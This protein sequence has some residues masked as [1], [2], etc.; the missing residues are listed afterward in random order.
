MNAISPEAV[1]YL[2]FCWAAGSILWA[3]VL[4]RV[5]GTDPSSEGSGNPGARNAGRLLGAPAFFTVFTGDALK[6]AAAVLA[7]R[8][9]VQPEW[10]IAAGGALAVFG[11]IFPLYGGKGGKGVSAFVGAALA[12]SPTAFAGFAVGTA[13]ALLPL[14]SATLTMP[15]GFAAWTAALWFSGMLPASWPL[16]LAAGLVL[17]RHRE[18]FRAAIRRD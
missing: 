4:G 15:G 6:G 7:G 8:Y 3:R 2:A 11:H 5:L 13:A 12:F 9:L 10:L 18:D 16:L 14:G 1:L 17:V